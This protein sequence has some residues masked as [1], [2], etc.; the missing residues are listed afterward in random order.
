M[1]QYYTSGYEATAIIGME[2][3][4]M[5]EKYALVLLFEQGMI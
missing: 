5:A 4:N 3:V 2:F 1:A